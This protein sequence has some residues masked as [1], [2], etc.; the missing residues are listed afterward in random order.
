MGVN[1][2]TIYVRLLDEGVD[3]WRPVRAEPLGGNLY[4]LA[5][6][7]VPD[8][9]TW[10]FSPGA[11]VVTQIRLLAVAGDPEPTLVASGLAVR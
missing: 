4:R 1:A 11:V 6:T 9:E 2:V 3:V 8:T 10:E 5:A 7:P